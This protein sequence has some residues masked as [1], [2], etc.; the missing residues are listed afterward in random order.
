[1][2]LMAVPLSSVGGTCGPRLPARPAIRAITAAAES[3]TWLLVLADPDGLPGT[4]DVIRMGEERLHS[5]ESPLEGVSALD[6]GVDALLVAHG[7]ICSAAACLMLAGISGVDATIDGWMD[8][9]TI[10]G[11]SRRDLGSVALYMALRS[12]CA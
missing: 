9:Y 12:C 2:L 1:M 5:D 4:G 7:C 10:A 11:D 3:I 6:V 8:L